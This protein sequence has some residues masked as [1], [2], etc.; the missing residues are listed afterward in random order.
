MSMKD[1]V[2]FEME[3]DLAQNNGATFQ[4]VAGIVLKF[5]LQMGPGDEQYRAIAEALGNEA[6]ARVAEWQRR[7]G[8]YVMSLSP[9]ERNKLIGEE[10]KTLWTG[11]DNITDINAFRHKSSD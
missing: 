6:E 3:Q 8:K 4:H 11:S 1:K 5:G 2:D 9:G 7:A 10:R